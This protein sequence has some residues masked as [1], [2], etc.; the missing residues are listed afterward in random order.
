MR[1]LVVLSIFAFIVFVTVFVLIFYTPLISPRL[2]SAYFKNCLGDVR[3]DDVK[4]SGQSTSF[5]DTMTLKGVSL[6]LGLPDHDYRITIK[7]LVLPELWGFIITG[8]HLRLLVS[9]MEIT[10]DFGVLRNLD[11]HILLTFKDRKFDRWE[12]VFRKAMIGIP[13]LQL[14]EVSG[15]FR[16]DASRIEMAELTANIFKSACRGKIMLEYALPVN[17]LVSLEFP[18]LKVADLQVSPTVLAPLGNTYKAFMQF[19]GTRWYTDILS[20]DLEIPKA[21][22]VESSFL[23]EWMEHIDDQKT[24]SRLAALL[25]QKDALAIDKGYIRLEDTS[26]SRPVMVVD[27]VN[28]T[29]KIAIKQTITLDPKQWDGS[30]FFNNGL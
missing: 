19:I 14:S 25:E 6:H 21:G 2:F 18:Q 12:G 29:E 9:Q 1:K 13:L 3:L 15:R 7:N 22:L 5:P 27:L 8:Q 10:T 26:S 20:L 16:G 17:Y 4:V 28:G 11:G 23:K 24:K 30:N